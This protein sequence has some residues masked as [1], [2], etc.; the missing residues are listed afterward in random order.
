MTLRVNLYSGPGCGK[1]T[2]ATAVFSKLKQQ[3]VN[4]E[5]VSEVAKEKVW[6]GETESLGFQPL[7]AGEQQWREYRL[8]G[9]VDVMV[10]DTSALLSIVYNK[11]EAAAFDT[12]IATEYLRYNRLNVF[13]RRNPNRAYNPAGRSQNEDQ[14]V[15]LDREVRDVLDR[16]GVKYVEIEVEEDFGHTDVIVEAIQ[17]RLHLAKVNGL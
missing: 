11:G 1:S 10:S 16:Y 17:D 6:S 3:G 8:E 15:Q 4:C 2:T 9:K 5:Y 7:I 12:W 14:A 13:L